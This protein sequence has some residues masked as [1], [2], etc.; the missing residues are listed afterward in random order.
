[1]QDLSSCWVDVPEAIAFIKS[2]GYTH[3]ATYAQE[4]SLALIHVIEDYHLNDKQ[5]LDAAR[6]IRRNGTLRRRDISN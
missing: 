5:V 6:W 2:M 3:Y 1:M 4:R